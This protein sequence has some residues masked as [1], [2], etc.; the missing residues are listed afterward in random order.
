ML[1]LASLFAIHLSL[2]TGF[3]LI[4][5]MPT[6][7][8]TIAFPR[9]GISFVFFGELRETNCETTYIDEIKFHIHR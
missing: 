9:K 7:L 5:A 4:I 3:K 8:N 1:H 6:I 2:S